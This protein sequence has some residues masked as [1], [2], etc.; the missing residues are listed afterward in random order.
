MK[1]SGVIILLALLLSV[2]FCSCEEPVF[3]DIVVD[4]APVY[5]V[6]RSDKIVKE[7]K[8]SHVVSLMNDISD[9]VEEKSGCKLVLDNDWVKRGQEPDP[10]KYEILVGETNRPETAE[11][12]SSLGESDYAVRAVGNKIVIVG[13]SDYSLSLAVERFISEYIE[14]KGKG[15]DGDL[16][17]KGEINYLSEKLE[18]LDVSNYE[19]VYTRDSKDPFQYSYY[20]YSF[21]EKTVANDLAMSIGKDYGVYPKLTMDY[22]YDGVEEEYEIL[23]GRC[24]REATK[25][26]KSELA[27]NEYA[28]KVVGNKV[29]LTGHGFLTTHAAVKKFEQ[30]L[31]SF[32]VTEGGKTTLNIP[33]DL[34]Y[35]G[36]LEGTEAWD[37]SV[38]VY[39][40]GESFSVS[41]IGDSSYLMKTEGAERAGYDAL[42]SKLVSGGYRK[43]TENEIDGNLFATFISDK[44]VVNTQFAPS[45]KTVSVSVSPAKS[46]NLFALEAD[47]DKTV[48]TTPKLIQLKVYDETV[49]NGGMCYIIRLENGKFI[50]VDCGQEPESAELI[51][52]Q[53]TEHNVL[54]GDPQIYAWIFTHWH[55]DHYATY[56]KTFF[57]NYA[58]KVKI[59][60]FIY[61]FPMDRYYVGSVNMGHYTGFANSTKIGKHIKPNAGDVMHLGNMKLTFLYTPNEFLPH[62]FEFFNDSSLTFMIEYAG[63]KIL[64]TGDA[65]ENSCNIMLDM[66]PKYLKCDILQVPHHGHYGANDK[67]MD[68][69]DPAVAMIPAS[70]ARWEAKLTKNSYWGA[71]P[72][73]YLLKSKNLKEYYVQGMGT[74]VF[75][76]PYEIK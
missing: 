52:D 71:A 68:A 39:E 28:I 46:T 31:E 1:R 42:I 43:Y 24:E 63:Q 54:A 62:T 33:K 44:S 58:D 53:L 29:V 72:L 19:I 16:S 69:T 76:L 66:Y 8:L 59:E 21:D 73:R 3:T 64:I 40:G 5:T 7:D 22:V 9:A 65:S 50:V 10:T 56:T 20:D 2:I 34:S 61:S 23:L 4:G 14:K 15:T 13:K 49:E 74:V 67:F 12:L 48:V 32:S 45:R 17:I 38:P 37:L 60:N 11:V 30:L 36:V 47:N 35:V 25:A 41:D 75:E 26:V 57:P 70:V 18:F 51:Y 55:G 27:F 6:I